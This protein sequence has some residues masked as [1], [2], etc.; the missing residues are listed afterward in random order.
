MKIVILV[1]VLSGIFAVLKIAGVINW[2]WWLIAAPILISG[3]LT[4]LGFVVVMTSW[5]S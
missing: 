3:A 5:K 2:S 4:V 1:G